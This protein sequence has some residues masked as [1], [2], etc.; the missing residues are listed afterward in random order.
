MAERILMILLKDAENIEISAKH[1]LVSPTFLR[2]LLISC[3]QTL[4]FLYNTAA[5]I[6]LPLQNM[7]AMRRERHPEMTCLPT[8]H[9]SYNYIYLRNNCS[10]LAFRNNIAKTRCRM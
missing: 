1:N 10:V 2:F 9:Q 7:K 4:R 5:T 6:I 3:S 8:V